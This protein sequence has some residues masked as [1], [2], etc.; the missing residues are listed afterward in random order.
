MGPTSFYGARAE[1]TPQKAYFAMKQ[2]NICHLSG[3]ITNY[4]DL[5]TQPN[6]LAKQSYSQTVNLVTVGCG[7][8]WM[9]FGIGIR[10]GL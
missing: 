3:D 4:E 2:T 5:K 10:I 1:K 9:D 6:N 8:E 7:M